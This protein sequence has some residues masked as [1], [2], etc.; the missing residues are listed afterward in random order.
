M[1]KQ[2]LIFYI[3]FLNFIF[4]LSIQFCLSLCFIGMIRVVFIRS[5]VALQ[6]LW[7]RFLCRL[8]FLFHRSTL[9][10]I[11]TLSFGRFSL[12]T[13]LTAA[14]PKLCTQFITA[15]SVHSVCSFAGFSFSAFDYESVTQLCLF[16]IWVILICCW[17]V[18]NLQTVILKTLLCLFVAFPLST[19]NLLCE[20]W[21]ECQTFRSF[22]RALIK[23]LSLKVTVL[24]PTLLTDFWTAL[25]HFF[26]LIHRW[27]VRILPSLCQSFPPFWAVS[28]SPLFPV[29]GLCF[30][31]S[32]PQ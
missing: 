8:R 24:L 30:H 28:S 9:R 11:C 19:S 14:F 18:S 32:V 15:L 31:S 26:R 27:S 4:G 5:C 6:L 22:L 29:W 12:S 1:L 16:F 3:L 23:V 25:P 2:F 13:Q 7:F 17:F 20:G 21:K 10:C